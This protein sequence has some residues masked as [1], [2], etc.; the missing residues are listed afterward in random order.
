MMLTL[1]AAWLAASPPDLA[2]PNTRMTAGQ[3]YDACARFVARAPGLHDGE[4]PEEA[5]CAMTVAIWRMMAAAEAAVL[6]T[7][8]GP[9][10][11]TYCAPATIPNGDGIAIA[12][13]FIA[14]VDDHPTVRGTDSEEIFQRALVEKWPCPR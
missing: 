11:R 6:E 13:T 10:P 2:A 5:H 9:D 14:Y 7:G 1:L 3:L 8:G 12:R 4:A